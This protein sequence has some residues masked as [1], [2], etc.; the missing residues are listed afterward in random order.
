[1]RRPL[2]RAFRKQQEALDMQ[3]VAK[4]VGESTE[5]TS[6]AGVTAGG[7][8][9]RLRGIP[10]VGGTGGAVFGTDPLRALLA[11]EPRRR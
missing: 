4:I 5:P 10:V 6:S 8:G 3:K 7:D 9:R 1:M 11:K 2:P